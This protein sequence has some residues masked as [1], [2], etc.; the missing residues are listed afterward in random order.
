MGNVRHDHNRGRSNTIDSRVKSPKVPYSNDVAVHALDIGPRLVG[1]FISSE[2]S[3]SA[4][5]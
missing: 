2:L 1:R 3:L 5:S 4:A